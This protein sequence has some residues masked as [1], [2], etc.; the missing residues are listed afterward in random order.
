MELRARQREC[1]PAA[2]KVSR[3]Y[4][5]VHLQPS[6][7]LTRQGL[8]KAKVRQVYIQL[9]MKTLD[10][11]QKWG[12]V[13]NPPCHLAH[14]IDRSSNPHRWTSVQSELSAGTGLNA[15]SK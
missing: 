5:V 14:R 8:P 2:V 6:I 12:D 3:T 15:T 1:Y 10:Y 4:S 7:A 11:G 9:N 13:R